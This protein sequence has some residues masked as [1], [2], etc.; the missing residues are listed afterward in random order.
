MVFQ[1]NTKWRNSEFRER[2]PLAFAIYVQSALSVCVSAFLSAEM[3]VIHPIGGSGGG[4]VSRSLG[5]ALTLAMQKRVEWVEYLSVQLISFSWSFW[6]KRGFR[7]KTQGLASPSPIWKILDPPLYFQIV[8]K[9]TLQHK[10]HSYRLTP[11]LH[12]RP[13]LRWRTAVTGNPRST[14]VLCL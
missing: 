8:A 10:H 6:Q 11:P 2:S 7:K 4:G 3:A 13:P 1:N 14:I 9:L 5:I 12:W